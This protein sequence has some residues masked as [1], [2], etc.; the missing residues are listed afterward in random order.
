LRALASV[1]AGTW[2][3]G[4]GAMAERQD[5]LL[6]RAAK[7]TAGQPFEPWFEAAARIDREVKGQSRGEPWASLAGLVA[8][9]AGSALPPAM[10][11]G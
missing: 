11:R 5:A 2:K 7:R 6:R 8:A 3:K 10:L 4:Y 9:I 1:R